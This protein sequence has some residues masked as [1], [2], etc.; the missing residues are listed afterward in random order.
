M[1]TRGFDFP[2]GREPGRHLELL[3]S[4]GKLI[5]LKDFRTGKKLALVRLEAP[6]I[7]R[8]YPARREDRVLVKRAQLPERLVQTLLMVEDRDFHQHR[9][10]DVKGIA[11]AAWANLRAGRIVQGGSTLTQQLVKNFYLDRQRSLWRKIN[12]A[13]MSL[14]LERRYGKDEILE[15]YA[16]E[17]YLGQDGGRAIH[18][19]GLASEFYFGRAL[20]ELDTPRLAL[21]VALV[22]GPSYYDP[23]R[24][25]Q[26]AR[27][28]RN[29]VLRILADQGV[30]GAA[31]ERA[32]ANTGLGVI[33]K[34]PRG[35]SA[36]PAFLQL[37]KRQL[38]RDY[39][40]QDLNTEGLR[41]FSTMDPW[42]QENAEKVLAARL[43]QFEKRQ[44]VPK[45]KLQGALVIA[46]R[47]N[48]EVLSVVGGRD[49]RYAGF[50]RAL[51]A[52]R[53]IGSLIKPV[54]YLAALK[55]PRE[56][57]LRS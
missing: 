50:N 42:V 29:L 46:S 18:G 14:L 44:V 35:R 10:I 53:P 21:L 47:D 48:G 17:I 22:R 12:E 7:G 51:D 9:G 30:I 8:F 34:V 33:G 6:S 40:E 32:A 43:G 2:D 56:Y 37:V 26:R 15:A 52:V 27:D 54:V 11:R 19:F 13:V 38:H 23:R 3:F 57:T 28:R 31:E 41:I 45:G 24:H 25:P 5:S 1:R 49:P 36:Y 39:R 55:R 16:N 4:S 20:G